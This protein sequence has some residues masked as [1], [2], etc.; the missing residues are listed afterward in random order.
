[1]RGVDILAF[2]H[3]ECDPAAT[4]LVW[5]ESLI[6]VGHQNRM[7]S[8]SMRTVG[9]SANCGQA[10]NEQTVNLGYGA[11]LSAAYGAHRVLPRK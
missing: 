9:L 5:D 4:W 11:A 2:L 3:F 7:P 8:G 1:L 6:L 10:P